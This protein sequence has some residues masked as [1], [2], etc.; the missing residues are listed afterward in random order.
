MVDLRP[1]RALRYRSS[2]LTRRSA[3]PYDVIDPLDRS[4]L[5]AA[6][7]HNVVRLL[8]P[9]G[10]DP[11]ETAA[12]LLRAWIDE[13][14]L[15]LDHHP[16]LYGYRMDHPQPDGGPRAVT[17][18]LGA[19]TLPER[20]G[21][22]GLFPHERTL[23]KARSDRLRL[24]R[25][26][27]T[28]LDPIWCLA[29]EPA[30]S[31]LAAL[32]ADP[33]PPTLAEASDPE[34]VR[35]TLWA[36]DDPDAIAAVSRSV[37]A[38][39]LVVADG[40]HRLE[41]AIAWRDELRAAGADVPG[42]SSVLAFVTPLDPAHLRV[43]PIHRLLSGTPPHLDWPEA[44]SGL[45]VVAE[46]GPAAPA[47]ARSLAASLTD[48]TVGVVTRDRLLRCTVRPGPASLTRAV[49]PPALAE[50]GSALFDELLRPLLG[51]GVTVEFRPDAAAVAAAVAAGD[52]EVGVLLPP[53]SIAQIRG[54]A[55]AGARMPEKTSYF[56]P[57]PR[58]GFVLRPV[59]DDDRC[60]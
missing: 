7:P 4:V 20:L 46:A 37:T 29:D 16:R 48:G 35:H 54:A 56:C 40:H 21:H 38:S 41:T 50:V 59:D 26:T 31:T 52:A 57:K 28:N 47:A 10:D 32:L 13:G 15:V 55:E 49:L 25:A 51:P 44:L 27:R 17:G 43:E 8:L 22:D 53:V 30:A 2:D 18:V 34:G 5:Q 60:R 36:V 24:L 33:E 39:R 42:A 45:F 1:F 6:D 12:A 3:P 19:L 9:E 14:I 23:P 11:Y 58:S